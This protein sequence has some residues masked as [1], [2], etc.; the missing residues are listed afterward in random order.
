MAVAV[1]WYGASL[2]PLNDRQL[3]AL[4]RVGAA[5]P[6]ITSQESGLAV[7]IYALRDRGL[8]V[9]PRRGGVW[10]AELT[11]AGRFYLEHGKHPDA[12]DAPPG[13][14]SSAPALARPKSQPG[15]SSPAATGTDDINMAVLLKHLTAERRFVVAD[16]EPT[17]R[18]AWRRAIDAAKRQGLVPDGFHLRH[19]GRDAGD[20]VVELVEGVHPEVQ[21]RVSRP[22]PVEVPERLDEPHPVV[23]ALRDRPQ[24]LSVSAA[25]RPRALRLV[26]V[27]VSEAARRGHEPVVH[28]TA[29]EGFWISIGED[30][31]QLLMSEGRRV[32]TRLPTEE[33]LAAKTTYSWQRVQPR[34]TEEHSGQLVLELPRDYSFSGRRSRWGD[35]KRWR[36]DDKLGELLAELEARAE[37]AR[38]KRAADERVEADRRAAEARAM[39]RA[40]RRFVEHHRDKELMRQVD[41]WEK[42]RRIR[43]Y[44]AVV[45]KTIAEADPGEQ[46]TAAVTWVRWAC[47]YADSLDPLSGPALPEGPPDREPRPGEL[48]SL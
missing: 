23:A 4:R 2:V 27:L 6:P 18:A 15:I 44:C 45:E 25:S 37:L 39:V 32:E 5:D 28:R 13:R 22:A 21:R 3:A 30:S 34:T 10:V 41:G 20:L 43:E 24:L 29:G 26:Q 36:L 8:V 12:P 47:E 46:A 14:E 33:E 9:A 19:C 17:A 48:E 11:A 38:A 31:F 40:R 42:A 35:G 1:R 16:P 7:T